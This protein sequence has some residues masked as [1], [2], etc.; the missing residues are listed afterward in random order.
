[1]LRELKLVW[2]E[3]S[4]HGGSE[5]VLKKLSDIPVYKVDMQKHPATPFSA[6][7]G[8]IRGEGDCGTQTA[9]GSRNSFFLTQGIVHYI[10]PTGT[11][12]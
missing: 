10:S 5:Y 1:M 4:G 6:V 2:L 3:P 11:H 7:K 12:P 8:P 9:T